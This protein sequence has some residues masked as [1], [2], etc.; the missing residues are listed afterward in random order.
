MSSWR[1]RQAAD[2][3]H[4]L[5]A[6]L[7]V[8]EVWPRDAVSNVMRLVRAFADVVARWADR[9]GHFLLIEAFPPTAGS[10]ITDW[11]RVLGLPEPCFPEALTLDERRLQI[12]EKLAR[13][14][15]GQSRAYFF[16]I[17]ERLGYHVPDDEPQITITEFRPFMA[18]VSRCG[19][20][21]W[22][23]APPKMRFLWV[24]KVPDP[25][26]TW[27]RSGSS[28]AGTDPHLRIARA[29]DL[30]CVFDKLKPAH[31]NLIFDYSG[32]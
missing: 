27:F 16:G 11:E 4:A 5:A 31:S 1:P 10:L 9:V 13:R 8:G 6:L 17:A 29:V 20:P 21:T 24:V 28:H 3:A 26:L 15:G 32:A 30:E 2:Y 7:P 19:D 23:I 18:G 25:R 14:P 12:R 22:Q